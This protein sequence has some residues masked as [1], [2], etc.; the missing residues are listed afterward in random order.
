MMRW[1]TWLN[2]NQNIDETSDSDDWGAL[3]AM[4]NSGKIEIPGGLPTQMFIGG[5]HLDASGKQ[6]IESIDPATG[7][8]FADIPAGQ[9]DDVNRAVENSKKSFHGEWRQVLPIERARILSR[10][11][12]LIRRDAERLSIIETLDSGKPITESRGVRWSQK[13]GQGAKVLSNSGF[14]VKLFRAFCP[15]PGTGLSPKSFQGLSRMLHHSA[16][17]FWRPNVFRAFAVVFPPAQQTLTRDRLDHRPGFGRISSGLVEPPFC[18]LRLRRHTFLLLRPS[19]RFAG[20]QHF[21]QDHRQFASQGDAGLFVATALFDPPRPVLQRMRL[22]HHAQ[23]AVGS[24]IQK[25]A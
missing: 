10:T 1:V 11:A 25:A 6:R 24:L 14:L 7:Q 4:V 17:G 22:A 2:F 18:F 13:I 3:R 12:A 15:L 9:M 21:V 8:V 20:D 19:K 16:L 5:R 23:Q